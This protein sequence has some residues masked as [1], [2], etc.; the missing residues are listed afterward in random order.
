MCWSMDHF[1]LPLLSKRLQQVGSDFP[2]AA[3]E[4]TDL[5][6]LIASRGAVL[7]LPKDVSAAAFGIGHHPGGGSHSPSNGSLW[8]RRQPSTRFLRS[9]SRNRMSSPQPTPRCSSRQEHFL[10]YTVPRKRRGRVEK[11]CLKQKERY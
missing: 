6:G 8:V 4:G 10:L 3:L 9:C 11:R 2:H 5:Q 7:Q 1:F